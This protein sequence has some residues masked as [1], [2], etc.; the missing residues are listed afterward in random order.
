MRLYSGRIPSSGE[1]E[2]RF[3]AANHARFIDQ[4]RRG[5]EPRELALDVVPP[6]VDVMIAD[7]EKD[8]ER[9]AQASK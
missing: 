2:N 8:A 3:A 5:Y 7:D 1:I 4:H 9:R 6:G